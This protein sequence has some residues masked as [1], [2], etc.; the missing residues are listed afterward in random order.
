VPRLRPAPWHLLLLGI[1][2]E[3][4]C[5]DCL[6]L[7]PGRAEGCVRADHPFRPICRVW[8]HCLPGE[9]VSRRR[10]HPRGG[11]CFGPG[12][13][14][15]AGGPL[16]GKRPGRAVPKHRSDRKRL[17]PHAVHPRRKR[18]LGAAIALGGPFQA[19]SV[20]EVADYTT[21]HGAQHKLIRGCSVP[22]S[23]CHQLLRSSGLSAGVPSSDA[24]SLLRGRQTGVPPPQGRKEASDRAVQALAVNVRKSDSSQD[25]ETRC[26]ALAAVVELQARIDTERKKI[27]TERKKIDD[28]RQ[29][30]DALAGE[31]IKNLHREVQQAKGLMTARGVFERVAELAFVEQ[32]C[33]VRVNTSFAID[34]ALNNPDPKKP[35][36]KFLFDTIQKCSG[37]TETQKMINVATGIYSQLSQEVHGSPWSGVEVKLLGPLDG[38]GICVIKEMCEQMGL[39]HS[40]RP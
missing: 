12:G 39:P 4:G 7:H 6:S 13:S 24:K 35:W 17:L 36:S 29:K 31:V 38:T 40:P 27:D 28:E 5:P 20:T 32:G 25:L 34:R 23:A 21:R 8:A 3:G 11:L 33:K 19:V 10:P 18:Q 30:N 9:Q 2:S 14:K 1:C 22:G 37:E 15:V 16:R 26:K